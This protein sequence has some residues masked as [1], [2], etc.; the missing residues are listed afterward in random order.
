MVDSDLFLVKNFSIK[1]YLKD[2]QLGGLHQ[3]KASGGTLIPYL[4]IGIVFMDMS[5]LPQKETL[6]FNC[7]KIYGVS[8]DAGG[9]THYYLKSHPE[10]KVKYSDYAHSSGISCNNCIQERSEQTCT[11]NRL[12]LQERGF[13]NQQINALQAGLHDVEF[14]VQGTFFH[15]RAGTNWNQQSKEYHETKSRLLNQ[16]IFNI[17]AS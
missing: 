7:G 1:N 2:Y 8:V 4:W 10:V 12:Q 13:D 15:Y 3:Q 16:Y 14:F 9:F 17:M 11:H 5:Q 6:N